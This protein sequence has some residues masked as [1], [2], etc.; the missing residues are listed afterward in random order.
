M[1]LNYFFIA[2]YF[3]EAI[4]SPVCDDATI[5]LAIENCIRDFK[6]CINV[7]RFSNPIA[8]TNTSTETS[9]PGIK[10]TASTTEAA[11]KST[12]S[13]TSPTVTGTKVIY[14]N[15]LKTYQL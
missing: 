9:K 11:N 8:V 2:F 10:T 12:T 15:E 3:K 13:L 7:T 4:N 14:L 1:L 5:E 6:S